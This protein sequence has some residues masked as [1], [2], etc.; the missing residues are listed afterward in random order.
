MAGQGG[1]LAGKRIL[2][3]ESRDLDLF[4]GMMEQHGA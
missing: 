1:D 4:A 3:P 2:V